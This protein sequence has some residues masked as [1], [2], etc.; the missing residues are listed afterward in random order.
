MAPVKKRS[1]KPKLLSS[2]RPPTVRTNKTKLSSKATRNLIR[3]HHQLM[4]SRAQA[5][6]EGNEDLVRELDA[7]IEASGGLESYQLASKLGQ[8]LERGGDSSK[9][10]I[11]WIG[12]NL[13]ELKHS[14]FKLRMLEVGAL[15]TKNACT[16]SYLFD[17]TRID[18]NSQEPG[19]LK[20]D[21]MKRPL[22]RA[23]NDRFHIISLSLVLNY[24]PSAIGRGDMLKRC[25]EFLTD[26]LP[27]GLSLNIRP[28]LFLV[29]PLACVKNSRYLTEGRLQD[30]L[31]SMGFVLAKSKETSKLIFQLW[32]HNGSYKP[33]PFKKELLNPGTIR[34]NFAIIVQ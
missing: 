18:L 32:E 23:D 9:V 15:S 24:V 30:I 27:S 17:V 29:L 21:F 34:N 33:Q 11:D 16:R 6:E 7:R 14:P 5:V 31:S 1:K 20:Q 4:K 12:P 19:I 22:P 26:K 8:S 13:V 2:S 10:L 3:S 25:V 28:N